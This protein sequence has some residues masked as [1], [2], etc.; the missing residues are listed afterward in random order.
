MHWT[1]P[2][3]AAPHFFEIVRK[4]LIESV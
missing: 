4:S 1:F 2:A 3:R